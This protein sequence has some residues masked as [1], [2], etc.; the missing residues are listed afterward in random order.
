MGDHDY[1]A[2]CLSS[3]KHRDEDVRDILLHYFGC[4]KVKE[5]DAFFQSLPAHKQHRIEAEQQRIDEQRAFFE[6][7]EDTIGL[8]QRLRASLNNY[9]RKSTRRRELPMHGPKPAKPSKENCYS[10]NGY[11]MFFKDSEPFTDPN[12]PDHF[13]NQKILIRDLLYDEDPK[14]NPLMKPCG[15]GEIRYFHLPGNNMEWVEVWRLSLCFITVDSLFRKQLL[16]ISTKNDPS[17]MVFSG[18][19][20]IQRSRICYFGRSSREANS[21]VGA[22]MLFMQDT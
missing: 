3:M 5:R 10:M 17:T 8:V 20:S 2:T 1:P 4:L 21:T 14:S 13:P 18:N 22:T 16:V 12:Y 7:D 9:F 6:K 11:M 15:D 19:L